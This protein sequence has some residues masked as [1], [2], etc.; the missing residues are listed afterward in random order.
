MGLTHDLFMLKSPTDGPS[1]TNST[2]QI[3][4]TKQQHLLTRFA[5]EP[6][7]TSILK[8]LFERDQGTDERERKKA[9]HRAREYMVEDGKL[10]QVADSRRPQA[11][12]RTEVV[13]QE[14][15]LELAREEHELRGHY[16]RD[17]IKLELMDHY[18]GTHTDQA[19]VNGI[20]D[21]GVCA[22]FGTPHLH[23]LLQPVMQRHPFKLFVADY[24]S[25]PMGAGGFHTIAWSWTSTRGSA[26]ASS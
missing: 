14:E 10:W 21:C 4:E 7:H 22:N 5:K 3:L 12:A 18:T 19:I 26:G 15:M 13:S 23:S 1:P 17:M 11:K 25:M 24:L 16:K 20:H 2:P 8:A 9:A 6:L